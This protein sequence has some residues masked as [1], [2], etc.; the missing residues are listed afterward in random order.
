MLHCNLLISVYCLQLSEMHRMLQYQLP[1][2]KGENLLPL[3]QEPYKEVRLIM[4]LLKRG[5]CY[6]RGSKK[7]VS[8]IIKKHIY[9]YNRSVVRFFY[10]E[11]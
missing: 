5:Y 7:M 2:I 6:N 8:F 9:P 4:L 11:Q 1:L 10:V 3:C